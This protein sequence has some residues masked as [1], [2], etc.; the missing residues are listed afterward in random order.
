[1]SPRDR[2][3]FLVGFMGSGKTAVG[4]ALARLLGVEFVDTDRLVEQREGRSIERIFGESGEEHFR[5]VEWEVLR[6]LD[7]LGHAVVATGGGMF[8]SAV[9]R[10]WMR[11]R[12]IT[13]WLDLSLDEARRRVGR[14]AERPLWRT[15][16][17]VG[18]RALFERRRAAYALCQL[19]VP[20]APGG[21]A[22]VA[23][24]VIARIP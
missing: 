5:A 17:P 11:R 21:P 22:D 23:R 4:E 24:R 15:D 2:P 1:V 7:G 10:R 16:D 20:A 6:S 3:I 14:G 8:L 19:R 18:Q 13:V 9:Q 12:G